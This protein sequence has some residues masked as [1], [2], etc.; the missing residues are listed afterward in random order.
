MG[1]GN[2]MNVITKLSDVCFRNNGN[3]FIKRGT[4][5]LVLTL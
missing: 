4:G 3:K 1:K 5:Y 2:G